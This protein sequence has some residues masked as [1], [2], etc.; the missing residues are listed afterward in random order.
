[1]LLLSYCI[2][3]REA[4]YRYILNPNQG[5]GGESTP[6]YVSQE[7]WHIS[8]KNRYFKKIQPATEPWDCRG[9]VAG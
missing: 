3:Y 5:K 9:S 6:K 2:A 1:M 7:N 8:F 4:I